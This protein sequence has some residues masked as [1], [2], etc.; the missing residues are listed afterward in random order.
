H[1]FALT[2]PGTDLVGALD[3]ANYCIWCHT[4]GKDS[5]SK[6]LKERPSPE[7]PHKVMFKKSAFGVTLAGCPL[8][9]KISEFHTLKAQGQAI[10]ALA[11]IV[12]DNP[13]VAATG[14]RICNDCMK[15]CIYQ[16][17]DAV[18][19][20]QVETRALKDVLELPFGFEIYSLLT[21]WNPLNL[22]RPY[23][24]A[25]TGRKVLVVGLGPAGYTLAHH[26]LNDGHTVV[27]IDGLKIEPLPE[28]LCGLRPDGS[29]TAFEV[30]RD[31]RSI[32]EPL[33]QRILAGFGGVA[34]YG[35]TVRWDKNNLKLIRLLLARRDEFAHFG[36]VRFGG[37]IDLNDAVALGFDHIAL[38]MGAGKPTTLDVP[39]GLARGVRSASDFLMALQL[40]GAAKRD[41]IANLQLRLPVV[42]IGGG[43]TAIDAATESLAYYVVQVDKFLH[44]YERLADT[45]GEDEIRDRWDDLDREIAEE[46]LAHARALRA[47][48]E[49]ARREAR[50]ARIAELLRHWGGATIVYRR[51]LIDSP[52]YTL[53]HE[54]VE[55]ALEEG[56]S[57]IEAMS[58]AGIEVD[59]FGAVKG[60]RFHRQRLGEDGK[61]SAE[62]EHWMSAH[63]VLVAAGTSPNT[64]LA[65]EDPVHLGLDGKYFRSCD[66]EGRPVKPAYATAKPQS[67][68][69][70]LTRLDSGRFVSFFGDLHPS[71]FGNVVKAMASARQGYPRI[72]R[73]L[74]RNPAASA[75]PSREFFA[76]LSRDLLATVHAVYRLTPNI[77]EIIVK[78]PAAARRFRPGQFYRLQNFETLSKRV[79][80]T[81]LHTEG[82]ALTGAWVDAQQGL[83]SCI[84][85]EMGGSSNLV[86][87]LAPGE[88]VILMGPTGMPTEIVSGETVLLAGGGLGNAVLFSIGQAFKAHG[89]RVLYFAGYKKVIDRYKVDEIEAAADVVVWCCDEEPGFQPRRPQDRAFVGNIVQGME[90]YAT[91]RLGEALIRTEEV[92]RIIAIGSDR[93]MAGVAKARHDVLKQHLKPSHCAIGSINS[94]MQCMMKEICAQCLQLHRD[95]RTGKSSVVF[96]C[97]NQD[98]PLDA[99]DFGSLNERLKQNAL[100]EKLTAQWLAH[101]A[102]PTM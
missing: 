77:V 28:A 1:G 55:K 38:C 25:A 70:L 42:V 100:Q 82:L 74:E 97:F 101:C 66:E 34:E 39:N 85:L 69:V 89:S 88:P 20:P 93:M 41:S 40:T 95:P 21:R 75:L 86:A 92:D 61:W 32:A 83:V 76:R 2:D 44:R 57:F 102:R 91:G 65:R 22:S 68:D 31:I 4:Q 10:S 99:V 98:Q 3:Q 84:V 12:I 50:P 48:R 29:R 30:L 81:R 67:A 45:T 49:A 73:L 27:G 5:C 8:E 94:P 43:L 26:L 52:S 80:N 33:D 47:E 96:S 37:T 13:T 23:P 6:G 9:E 16:K 62:G 60:I 7:A 14:H 35:I 63:T 59:N 19:I 24:R 54:E 90:A 72:S 64:V 11:V 87:T 15:A 46:F 56:V 36:G 58:P 17:Q 71:Y 51:R 18:D 53:N 79:A 78:A